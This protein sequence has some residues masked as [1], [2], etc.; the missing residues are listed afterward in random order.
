[1]QD[2]N[3]EKVPTPEEKAFQEEA[4]V[5]FGEIQEVLKRHDG[6]ELNPVLQITPKGILPTMSLEKK[7]VKSDI[8]KVEVP[9][10]E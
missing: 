8:V 2:Y 9:I 5:I 3:V 7:P 10:I 6:W 4:Q 1:M